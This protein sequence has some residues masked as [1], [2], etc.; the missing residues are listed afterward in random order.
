MVEQWCTYGRQT[1]QQLGSCCIDRNINLFALFGG[2][3]AVWFHTVTKDTFCQCWRGWTS[4]SHSSTRKF[5]FLSFISTRSAEKTLQS[6]QAAPQHGGCSRNILHLFVCLFFTLH[7]AKN[8]PRNYERL[9]AM[10][11]LLVL[12]FQSVMEAHCCR[13]GNKINRA[14]YLVIVSQ[15]NVIVLR[16]YKIIFTV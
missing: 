13:P 15:N 2:H 12:R 3:S 11:F 9:E 16:V 7:C 6:K 1:T 8:I 10:T 5:I 4:D 14:H